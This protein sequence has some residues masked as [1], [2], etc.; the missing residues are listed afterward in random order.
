MTDKNL[1]S[2]MLKYHA[3]IVGRLIHKGL[4]V[5]GKDKFVINDHS[6]RTRPKEIHKFFNI[7]FLFLKSLC[8]EISAF[9]D[10]LKRYK[11]LCL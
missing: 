6:S 11:R 5:K 2:L 4:V 1:F 7:H 3:E 8:R 10:R 9:H